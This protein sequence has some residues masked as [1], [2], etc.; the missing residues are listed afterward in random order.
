M[1]FKLVIWLTAKQEAS[2][3]E[4]FILNKIKDDSVMGFILDLVKTFAFNGI[5]NKPE[6]IKQ[7][8]ITEKDIEKQ[9]FQ[10]DPKFMVKGS[11]K[12]IIE[13]VGGHAI[14]EALTDLYKT[15]NALNKKQKRKLHP[16]LEAYL[17]MLINDEILK[18][19]KKSKKKSIESEI[20]DLKEKLKKKA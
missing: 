4:H 2:I 16:S 15:E 9:T 18:I 14:R 7:G 10:S 8:I 6:L 17:Y 19:E 3:T 11:S 13:F 1:S 5:E 12:K 20:S